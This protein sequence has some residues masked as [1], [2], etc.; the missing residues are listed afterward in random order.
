M[1]DTKARDDIRQLY[2]NS[3]IILTYVLLDNY[4]KYGR[5][6]ERHVNEVDS[7]TNIF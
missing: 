3:W 4:Y 6:R 5:L 7:G 2:A 1:K